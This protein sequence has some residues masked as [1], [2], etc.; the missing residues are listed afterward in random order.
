MYAYPHT[1]KKCHII[2]ERNVSKPKKKKKKKKI[3]KKKK[4]KSK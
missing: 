4:K 2:I 3:K 1:K